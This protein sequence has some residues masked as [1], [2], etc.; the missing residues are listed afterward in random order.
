MN[1]KS[2][3]LLAFLKLII[4]VIGLTNTPVFG[5]IISGNFYADTLGNR[6]YA[7]EIHTILLRN[8]K[9]ELSLPVIEA[10]TTQQLEL[11][12]DDLSVNPRTFGY[13]L[14]LCDA[15]WKRSELSPQEYLSGF[16]RGIIKE[17]ATSFNTTYDY[18]NYRLTFPEEDC[19]PLLSGNYALV[20]YEDDDPD[21]IIFTR[22]F[23][24]TEKTVKIEARVKQPAYGNYRETGQQVEFT[25]MHNGSDIRD[26]LTEISAV[27]MQNNRDDNMLTISK[28]FSIQSGQ[29]EYTD[30]ETGIFP[31]GN[32]FRSVDIKSMKYQTENIAAIEFQNPYYHVFMKPDVSRGNKPYFSKTDLN[33][34]YFIDREKSDDKH[35]EADYL[36][37]HFN[38]SLP[39]IYSGSAIFV[40]GGFCDWVKK[41]TNKMKYNA[42]KNCFELTLL[43]KQ[44]LYDYCFA[45]TDQQSGNINEYDLEGSYYET[46]NDYTIFIYF[47]DRHKGY[48]RLMGYL[49]LK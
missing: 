13:T 21:K 40:T 28:P 2:V 31:G 17:S 18:M 22:K 46:E 5:L 6:S 44:G 35:T 32:E 9:W 43:L 11:R 34:G 20:V 23:Y 8:A 47:H 3:K 26:P 36:F 27:I 38:L 1:L 4:I 49:T 42:G 45:T 39:P 7:P 48:D 30:P 24:V 15:N 16:G 29:L 37:V 10:G 19:L 12:F 33:G 25:V 41:D 14:V